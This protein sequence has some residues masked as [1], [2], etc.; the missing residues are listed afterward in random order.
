MKGE[1]KM[2]DYLKEF[3][4]KLRKWKGSLVRPKTVKEIESN[5]KECLNKLSKEGLIERAKWGGYW[6][7][8]EIKG[9]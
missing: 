8:T 1:H 6:I 9:V 2:P 4:E 3:H 5:A 7:S